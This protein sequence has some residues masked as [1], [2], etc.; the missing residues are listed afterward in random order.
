V[1]EVKGTG[2]ALSGAARKARLVRGFLRGDPVHC[3]W[4]LS[5]RCD[6][7]CH[8]CDHRAE[9]AGDELDAEECRRVSDALGSRTTLLVTFTGAEPFLRA[10]LPQIVEAVARRHFPL[11]VTNGWLV[12]PGRARAVWQAGLEAAT[13]AL[14]HSEAR[15]HDARAGL[16][17]AH[18]RAVAAL[19]TLCAERT[20]RTQRV[21]VRVRLRDAELDGLVGLLE[22]SGRHGATLSVE[23]P[24]PLPSLNGDGRRLLD[25]LRALKKRNP[26]LRTEGRALEGI[27]QALAGGV[28]GCQAGR[29][30][31]NV[32]HRGRVSKCALF[33]GPADRLGS[34]PRDTASLPAR[35]RAV[36]RKNECRDCWYASRAEVEG[37]Y[38]MR[39]FLGGLRAL[40]RA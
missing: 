16:A 15:R 38:T 26:H 9:G 20:R 12:T 25:G 4:Q 36:H 35:L 19:G 17:G 33:Q 6:S 21:N 31:F 13:V 29:A 34:L 1:A 10:E 8:L 23:L 24:Y 7:F 2:K 14:E 22:L 27:E 32:D 11:L 40:V 39:G 18:A 30:F 5:P 37:L 28:P 3:T